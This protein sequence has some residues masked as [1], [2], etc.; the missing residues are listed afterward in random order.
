MHMSMAGVSGQ[1]WAGV[2]D[3]GTPSLPNQLR[4]YYVS[5]DKGKNWKHVAFGAPVRGEWVSRYPYSPWP[6]GGEAENVAP[7]VASRSKNRLDVF[8]QGDNGCLWHK[9]WN[10]EEWSEWRDLGGRLTSTPGAVSWGH[11]RIDVFARG[12]DNQ[13]AHKRWNGDSWSGWRDLDIGP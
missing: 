3:K 1:T 8:I 9:R 4:G 12:F 11:N 5:T 13:L 7:A 10:G 6:A 2:K